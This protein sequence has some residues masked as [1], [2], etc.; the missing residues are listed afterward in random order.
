M[1]ESGEKLCMLSN[2]PLLVVVGRHTVRQTQPATTQ[3]RVKMLRPSPIPLHGECIC[4]DK[5]LRPILT[6]IINEWRHAIY[7]F[8]SGG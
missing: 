4:L 1:E 3:V 2:D 7:P 8:A 5:T 6:A